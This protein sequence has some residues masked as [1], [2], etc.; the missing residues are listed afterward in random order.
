[1]PPHSIQLINW[2]CAPAISC[3]SVTPATTTGPVQQQQ[4]Y[5]SAKQVWGGRIPIVM[6][7]QTVTVN[8]R[9]RFTNPTC[10]DDT[11]PA[12]TNTNIAWSSYQT[13]VLISGVPTLV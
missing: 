4:Y 8:L 1:M 13:I 2:T 10:E 5:F 7:G 11:Q 12:N 6:P 9:V 3:V